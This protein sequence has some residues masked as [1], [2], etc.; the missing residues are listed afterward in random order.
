[1]LLCLLLLSSFTIFA[2]LL[3]LLKLFLYSFSFSF[4][5]PFSVLKLFENRLKSDYYHPLV[6]RERRRE[7]ERKREKYLRFLQEYQ[8]AF[9]CE[10]V[11]W[12]VALGFS[13]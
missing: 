7:R 6:V 4:F 9:F 1:V 12:R 8:K 13:L 5:F 3:L 11:R 10:C 2:L